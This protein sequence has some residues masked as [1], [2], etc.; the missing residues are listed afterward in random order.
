MRFRVKYQEIFTSLEQHLDLTAT[1][2]QQAHQKTLK[3][4]IYVLSIKPLKRI[5]L[6]EK[7]NDSN[8]RY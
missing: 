2:L 7:N 8:C 3:L 6:A 4:D 5:Y 1:D